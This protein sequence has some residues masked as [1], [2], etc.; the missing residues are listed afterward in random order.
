M[1]L[2]RGDPIAWFF[3][4]LSGL[5]GGVYYPLD[6]MPGWMRWL[7]GW[8]PITYALQ[9]MRLALLQGASTM[10]LLPQMLTLAAFGL[11]LFPMSLISFRYAVRRAKQEGSLSHY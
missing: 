10:N 7:A 11:V 8:L 6:V 3:N 9:A 4:T 2:K 5:L 1:V